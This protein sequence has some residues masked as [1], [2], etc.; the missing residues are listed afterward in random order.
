MIPNYYEKIEDYCLDQLND[1]IKI[2][3]E[4]ELKLDA[5]LRKE[6]KLRMEIQSAIA[7][8]DVTNLR[9]LL[10]NVASQSKTSESKDDSFELLD[11]FSDILE[12]S[13][14]LSSED[15]IN[16]YDS[17]PKVHVHQ[18]EMTINENIHEFYKEQDETIV[19]AESEELIDMDF[20]EFEGLEDAILE[21]DI[22]NFRQTLSQVAKSVEP[23][24]TIEEIDDFL[25]EDLSGEE[26]ENFENEIANNRDLKAEVELHKE[27]EMAIQE[28]EIINLRNQV[29]QIMESETSWNVS[30][31]NIEAFID[32]ELDEALLAEFNAEL[33]ENSDL[34]AEVELRRQV[35]E[36]PGEM[37][38]Y[39]LRSAL[40]DA[41]ES[42]ETNKV[43]NMIPD[44]DKSLYKFLRTSVA[45]IVALIGIA[46]VLNSGY[47]SLDNAYGKFYNTP[48]WSAERSISVDLTLLNEVQSAYSAEDYTA[49]LKIKDN[50]EQNIKDNPVLNY[51]FGAS[52]QKLENYTQAI[53]E[54]TQVIK[55]GDNMFIEEAEWY[56]ALCY[57]KL[58]NPI[59]AKQELLAIVEKNSYFK[60]EARA[61]LRRLKFTLE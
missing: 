25:N 34:I 31:E 9:D 10:Q 49:V 61:V 21:K 1:Q 37:D 43:R 42:I 35:N 11:D 3:F 18:H 27:L 26:L 57:M 56:R 22:I 41:K 4:A 30:E 2:Q 45:I 47:L 29:S 38:V 39:K 54:Y 7:E 12:L 6:V 59:E 36:V 48:T 44:V 17:M 23:Q 8:K 13:E 14:E 32:G 20:A 58:G 52:S 5:E 16:Y 28:N 40:K 15:L 50:S 24:F 33:K 53:E 60:G 19:N 51:Y 46:G 55:H